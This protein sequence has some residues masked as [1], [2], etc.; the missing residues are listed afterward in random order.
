MGCL[1]SPQVFEDDWI[2]SSDSGCPSETLLEDEDVFE[3]CVLDLSSVP[4]RPQM[5]AFD[6]LDRSEK[7]TAFPPDVGGKPASLLSRR[8]SPPQAP[9]PPAPPTCE[10]LGLEWDPSV[11]IGRSVSHDDADSSYFSAGTGG[12]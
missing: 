2:L 11:D 4:N 7:A 3:K 5:F 9:P 1:L 12:K 8:P 6:A 10:H